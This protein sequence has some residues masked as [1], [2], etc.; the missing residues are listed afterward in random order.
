MN[1]LNLESKK[2]TKGT[3]NSVTNFLYEN[4]EVLNNGQKDLYLN[5]SSMISTE[6]N[7]PSKFRVTMTELLKRAYNIDSLIMESGA[8]YISNHYV[9]NK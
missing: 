5:I 2:T 8:V 9:N 3:L 7:K 1:T 6:L 4:K